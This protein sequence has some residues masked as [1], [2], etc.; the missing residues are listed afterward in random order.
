MQLLPFALVVL[1]LALLPLS[2]IYLQPRGITHLLGLVLCILH[3][4]WR[5]FFC[6]L[7]TWHLDTTPVPLFPV[8]L[9]QLTS[10]QSCSLYTTH[11]LTRQLIAHP[12]SN[13]NF[14]SFCHSLSNSSCHHHTLFQFLTMDIKAC[15]C[16][17][18]TCTHSRNICTMLQL[19]FH[20]FHQPT[21]LR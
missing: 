8:A 6:T 10:F 15:L 18:S 9:F 4:P 5:Y 16:I 11:T 2:C 7:C 20:L 14:Q 1:P 12:A 19:P 17:P 13:A 3:H 21:F